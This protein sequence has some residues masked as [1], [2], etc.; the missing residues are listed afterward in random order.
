MEKKNIILL[1]ITLA[2]GLGVGYFLNDNDSGAHDHQKEVAKNEIWTCSMH[3]QIQ[4]PEP[5]DC[6]ICGMDLILA[7]S[8]GASSTNPNAVHFSEGEIQQ[9]NIQVIEVGEVSAAKTIRLDGKVRVNENN[10]VVQSS[11]FAG[12]IEQIGVQYEGEFVNKGQLIAKV[13]SPELIKAQKE[14]IEAVKMKTTNPEI[15]EASKK[16]LASWKLTGSQIESIISTGKVI[17]ELPIFADNSGVITQLKVELGNYI[18][19]GQP[20]IHLTNLSSLWVELDAY[21]RD[22]EWL[23]TGQQ[24]RLKIKS[25]T[26]SDYKGK[27]DY[28]DPFI[29]AKTRTAKVRVVLNNA[30]ELKPEMFASGEIAVAKAKEQVIAIPKSAVMWTGERSIVYTEIERHTFTMKEVQLGKDLGEYYEIISG[31]DKGNRIVKT[32]TFVVDAAAQLQGKPSMMNQP[33]KELKNHKTNDTSSVFG[34]YLEATKALQMNHEK[35]VKMI[36]E[37]VLDSIPDLKTKHP[38]L[39]HNSG[40]TFKQGFSDFSLSLKQELKSNN[41]YLVKCPMANSDKGGFWL[42]DKPEV[43]NPYFGGDMLKCGS[44]LNEIPNFEQNE[45]QSASKKAFPNFHPLIVHFPIVLIVLA[46][47]FHL[48]SY[49]VTWDI[50]HLNLWVLFGG[51]I[52]ACI[53]AFIIHPHVGD[54]SEIQKEILEEHEWLSYITIGLSGIASVFYWKTKNEQ[55][56]WKRI[57]LTIILGIATLFISLSGHHGAQL[58]HIENVQTDL[59]HNH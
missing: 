48:L 55:Y 14:L 32:G 2:V 4:L 26:Q 40:D 39:L 47:L 36:L 53:S 13:Y 37:K 23:K 1:A 29:N 44:V 38:H 6:P 59:N 24:V 9:N 43:D 8:K 5:G 20:L 15:F 57:L 12:R 50:H 41:I 33:K 27:I 10:A 42:S 56:G 16:K 49:F 45:E 3:P 46:F 28:I 30:G 51:F 17:E 58:T 54:I 7:G 35:H 11:H 18:K 34:L 25:G 52:S 19:K 22:L 21:E 31:L